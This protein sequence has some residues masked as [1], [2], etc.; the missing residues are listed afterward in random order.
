MPLLIACS[1]TRSVTAGGVITEML[2][3]SSGRSSTLATQATPSMTGS[4]GFTGIARRP[5]CW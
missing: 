3:T 5:F 2:F 4:R 1:T